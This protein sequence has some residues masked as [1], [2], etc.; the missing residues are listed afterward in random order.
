MQIDLPTLKSLGVFQVDRHPCL[1]KKIGVAKEGL[2]LFG[3]LNNTKSKIG[4]DLLKQWLLQ[5]LMD[6]TNIEKRLSQVHYFKETIGSDKVSQI[7]DNLKHI[8]NTRYL[9]KRIRE[10]KA[11]ANDWTNLYM[12]LYCFKNLY[13]IC[14]SGELE[15]PIPQ[16]LD[17]VQ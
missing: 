13:E 9:L 12:S 15:K 1:S 3:I 7:Q 11:T 16:I 8:K 14:F 2:S 10:V 17:K 5:P 6:V 4:K